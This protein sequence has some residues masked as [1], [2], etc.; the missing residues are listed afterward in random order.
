MGAIPS[1]GSASSAARPSRNAFTRTVTS[2]R[3][4]GAISV[5]AARPIAATSAW[6]SSAGTSGGPHLLE[7][8]QP[9][10]PDDLRDVLVAVASRD[11]AAHDVRPLRDAAESFRRHRLPHEPARVPTLRGGLPRQLRE[12]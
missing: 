10:P 4:S 9:V 1:R 3:S 11:E 2:G 8:A 12:R 7:H 5:P 6:L